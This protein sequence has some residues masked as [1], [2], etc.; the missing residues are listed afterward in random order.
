M[1]VTDNS[2]VTT[3]PS[4]TSRPR[5]G[6]YGAT[7]RGASMVEFAL[8]SIVLFTLI[9]GIIEGAFAVNARSTM[10]NAVDDAARAG[11]IAGT[12]E[13]ADFRIIDGLVRRGAERA[14][15]IQWVTV[16][17]LSAN[18]S[19]INSC[20]AGTPDPGICNVY[21]PPFSQ[22]ATDYNC[23]SGDAANFCGDD[24]R[25]GAQIKFLGVYV[26]ATYD[27]VLQQILAEFN[28]SINGESIQAIESD[29]AI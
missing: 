11:A 24:R 15:D 2:R 13:D 18:P 25:G 19:E 10:S 23:S 16:Y 5:R 22:L 20:R 1:G 27:P 3:R 28:F 21:R 12:A 6:R 14:G 7:E 8:I 4:Q 9:F 17:D 29:G 26:E